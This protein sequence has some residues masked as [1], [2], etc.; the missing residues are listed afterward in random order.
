MEAR[1]SNNSSSNNNNN[2]NNN[3]DDA[4]DV[5]TAEENNSKR[6]KL[7]NDDDGGTTTSST[8]TTTSLSPSNT[9][10]SSTTTTTASY[11]PGVQST[12]QSQQQSSHPS[13][14]SQKIGTFD[15]VISSQACQELISL[16]NAFY[17]KGYVENLTICRFLDLPLW[18][19]PLLIQVRYECW[20]LVERYYHRE[21]ELYP[22]FT[23]IMGWDPRSFLRLH[24]DSNRPYLR[25]R[26]YSAVLYL[27][28]SDKG[29][30]GFVGG[31]LVFEFPTTTTTTTGDGGDDSINDTTKV[32]TNQHHVIKPRAGRLV[33]FPSSSD[34]KHRVLPIEKGCRYTVTMWFTLNEEAIESL[35]D[36]VMNKLS[37]LVEIFRVNHGI[38]DS[39]QQQQQQVQE[40]LRKQQ[41]SVDNIPQPWETVEETRIIFDEKLHKAGLCW[42]YQKNCCCTLD[43]DDGNNN[44]NNNNNNISSKTSILNILQSLS[45][46]DVL[47]FA[48]YCNRKLLEKG[49]QFRD[50]LKMKARDESNDSSQD[51]KIQSLSFQTVYDEWHLYREKSL[52][53]LLSAY[54]KRWKD[55]GMITNLTDDEFVL[56]ATEDGRT[57]SLA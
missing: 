20:Q 29:E 43:D 42:D 26:H 57:V 8:T 9:A 16:H 39:T 56:A 31:D 13:I 33:C 45:K 41:Q 2:N 44:N 53:G 21:L 48:S 38:H 54:A 12:Q 37:P 36:S 32:T 23:S 11:P 27:N 55:S 51:S 22:E 18:A 47:H 50:S 49:L 7:I 46:Q 4:P 28:D 19:T 10:S 35:E 15:G 6:R 17:H 24:Y 5:V 30:D 3:I 1:Q 52:H 34:Y 25:Q 40:L 14:L